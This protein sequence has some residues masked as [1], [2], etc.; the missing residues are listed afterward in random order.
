MT[1]KDEE[2]GTVKGLRSRGFRLVRCRGPVLER[3]PRAPLSRE[4]PG[5]E[6][7]MR[8]HCERVA[9]EERRDSDRH[10]ELQ[11]DACGTVAPRKGNQ[12]RP[13]VARPVTTGRESTASTGPRWVCVKVRGETYNV[14][15]CSACY[16]RWGK[17][18]MPKARGA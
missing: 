5:H 16:R 13:A 18:A 10:C 6:E 11:C 17:G 4:C 12:A 2:E 15:F 1:H 8:A 9:R 3:L 14:V 7:R